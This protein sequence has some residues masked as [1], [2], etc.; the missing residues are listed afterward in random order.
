MHKALFVIEPMTDEQVDPCFVIVR[1]ALPWVDQYHW[2]LFVRRTLSARPDCHG[3]ITI[4]W[5]G[6]RFPCGLAGYRCEFD[7]EHDRV[8]VVRPFVAIDP[9][10]NTPLLA[11]LAT[12]LTAI[13]YDNRCQAIRVV[14]RDNRSPLATFDAAARMVSSADEHTFVL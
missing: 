6:R 3:I 4:R 12:R 7:I 10:D 14:T 8:L 11:G 13:A 5:S 2:R 1:I 9:I